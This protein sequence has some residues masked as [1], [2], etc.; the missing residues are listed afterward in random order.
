MKRLEDPCRCYASE[1]RD[2][3]EAPKTIPFKQPLYTAYRHGSHAWAFD[4]ALGRTSGF[5]DGIQ[6]QRAADKQKRE[7]EAECLDASKR[8]MIT[9]TL[10]KA[11]SIYPTGMSAS[12]NPYVETPSETAVV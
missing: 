3:H 9:W 2:D 4:A 8:G 12:D 7:D 10:R 1:A 11:L 5:D 6:A